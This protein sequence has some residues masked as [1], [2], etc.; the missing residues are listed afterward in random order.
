M[1][2][3]LRWTGQNLRKQMRKCATPGARTH[4]ARVPTESAKPGGLESVRY[5]SQLEECLLLLVLKL[6]GGL[7]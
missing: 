7:Q 1:P 5:A 2:P 4:I 6:L 3:Q